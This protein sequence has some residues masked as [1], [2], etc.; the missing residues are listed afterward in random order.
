[1]ESQPL[2]TNFDKLSTS[3]KILRLQDLWDRIA[4]DADAVELTEAQKME[5]DGRLEAMEKQPELGTSWERVLAE[6][7]KSGQ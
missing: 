1:M 7:K 3:E 6:I 2:L 5:L 4:A